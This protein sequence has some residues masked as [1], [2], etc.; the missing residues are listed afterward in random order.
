MSAEIP[1]E[2]VVLDCFSE[3]RIVCDPLVEVKVQVDDLL[4]SFLHLV[5]EGDTYVL[6]SVDLGGCVERGV[7]FKP[8]YHSS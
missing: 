1:V 2:E 4:D 3:G 7:L 6:Q 5:V 8:L